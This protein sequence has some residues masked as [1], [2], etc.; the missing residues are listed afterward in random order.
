MADTQIDLLIIVSKP[1]QSE[2]SNHQRALIAIVAFS[3]FDLINGV[4][5]HLSLSWLKL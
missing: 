2:V 3:V 5:N 4:N 1:D